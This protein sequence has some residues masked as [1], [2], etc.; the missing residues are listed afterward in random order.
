M[1]SE[2][3]NEQL[4][5]LDDQGNNKASRVHYIDTPAQ[6]VQIN[7]FTWQITQTGVCAFTQS[8]Y[9]QIVEMLN[10]NHQH[11]TNSNT[12]S[13]VN[14]EGTETGIT[15][16]KAMLVPKILRDWNIDTGATNHMVSDISML[17]K[18]SLPKSTNTKYV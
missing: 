15:S 4:T 8:Q 2:E 10:Q 11:S 5:Q 16:S 1:F 17:N 12:G 14:V 3:A 7:Q 18:A 6:M 13:L 9:D